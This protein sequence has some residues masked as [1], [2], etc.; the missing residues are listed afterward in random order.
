MSLERN[1]LSVIKRQSEKSLLRLRRAPLDLINTVASGKNFKLYKNLEY[2]VLERQKL[3]LYV[4]RRVTR[5]PLLIFV[6]GGYWHGGSKDEY[7][8]LAEALNLEGFAVATVNYRLAPGATFPTWIRDI[9]LAL[10]WLRRHENQYQINAEKVALMGHSSGA[11]ITSLMALDARHLEQVGLSR[12]VLNAVVCLSGPYD[13]FDFI[14]TDPKTQAALGDPLHWSDT[15]PVRFADGTNPPM[16][17]LHGA[18]DTLVNP[19][20]TP[21]LEKALRAAKG[22]VKAVMFEKLDHF[23]MLGAF[24]KIGHWLE[25]SVLPTVSDFLRQNT[26]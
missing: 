13:F 18:K 2:G 8:F 14:L 4:P 1:W 7:T 21:A 22:D 19:L 16:L 26:N 12:D 11:H 25:P 6:H 10:R 17:L 5:A 20:N 3:D 15:Q 9:G 23:T 24:S